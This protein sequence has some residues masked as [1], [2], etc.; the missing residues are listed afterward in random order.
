MPNDDLIL[1]REFAQ[2]KSESAFATLVERHV[3]LVYSVALRQ[4]GDRHLAEDITQAVFI[5]LARKAGSLGRKIVLSAWLCRVA[6][7][8]SAKALRTQ[9]RRR[10]R[11]Q[12]AYMQSTLNEPPS[13][14]WR[15]IAPLL[16]NAL[17][18][19]G[20]TD[21]DALVL[22][23]FENKNFAEVGAAL[24]ASEDAAKVRVSRALEKLRKFFAARGVDSTTAAI[25]ETFSANCVHTAPVALARTVTAVALAKGAAVSTSTL[26]LIKGAL[27]IMAWTKAKTALV[28]GVALLAALGTATV[29][30]HSFTHSE[31]KPP[32]GF[33][34]FEKTPGLALT[35]GA[36]DFLHQL[37]LQHRLPGF[38]QGQR[39]LILLPTWLTN[40]E[41]YPVT[42]E[43]TV[44]KTNVAGPFP[45]HY[46]LVK[47]SVSNEWHLQKAWLCD[48]NG[49]VV[50][51]YPVN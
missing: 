13:E 38:Q 41:P 45:Y 47:P 51:E 23:F 1:L 49:K 20:R 42:R 11:E 17:E 46:L 27:K 8:A 39:A 34:S 22:R 43:L 35:Q 15:Q 19:L 12:E 31:K 37:A 14:H 40:A 9:S 30:I 4:T 10:Q 24:G 48:E 26:T 16:D 25:A 33:L 18:K 28:A 5:I 50:E 21:H 2:S 44:R 7:Y 6:R 3:N 32:V 36:V 29:A